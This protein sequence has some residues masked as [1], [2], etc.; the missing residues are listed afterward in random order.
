MLLGNIAVLRCHLP[1]FLKD[2]LRVIG[3]LKQHPPNIQNMKEAGSFIL[4]SLSSLHLNHI[5]KALHGMHAFTFFPGDDWPI[6]ERPPF[7][8]GVS[9]FSV[10]SDGVLHIRNAT[11]SDGQGLYRCVISDRLNASSR[12]ISGAGRLIVTRSSGNVPPRFTSTPARALHK[13][14]AE[15][16]ELACAVQA[17]PVPKYEWKYRNESGQNWNTL[18]QDN[19]YTLIGGSLIIESLLVHDQGTYQCVA[20]NSLGEEKAESKLTVLG[21]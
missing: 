11:P 20:S 13:K 19:R 16:I 17:F 14:V 8:M 5:P 6:N 9:R 7:N 4:D 1:T 10:F 2:H 12:R 21:K 15:R 3:W 18:A